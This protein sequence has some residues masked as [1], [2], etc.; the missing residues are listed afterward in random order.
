VHPSPLQQAV[1]QFVSR[2]CQIGSRVVCH[3][4]GLS[5]ALILVASAT[6]CGE[7]HF[8]PSPYTPQE[9]ELIYSS[10]EHITV[11]RWLVSAPLPVA[12]TRFEML[13]PNGY[14]PIDFSQSVFPGGLAACTDGFGTCAQ[15]VVRG[16][17][18]VPTDIKPVQAVHDVYGVLPGGPPTFKTATTTLS[19]QSFFH[20]KNSVVT[21]NITDAVATAG[22]YN[23]PRTYERTMWPTTGLCVSDTAPDGVSF[24][25]LDASSGFPPDQPLT[26]TGTYCVAAR[27]IPADGGD[28]AMVEVRI[29]TLPEIIRSTQ[30]FDPPVERS[31]IVYQIVLDL[32]I[33]VPD[34]CTD[35]ISKIENLTSKYMQGP[36]AEVRMLPTINLAENGSSQCAQTNDRTVDAANM[37]DQVRQTITSLTGKHMQY[38]LMYFNNLDA[39]LPSALTTSLQSLFD[40]LLSWPPNY[41]YRTFSWMFN[42]GAAYASPLSWWAFW[43]WETADKMFDMALADYGRQKLP[44]TSQE[45]DA[46]VPVKLL[47]DDDTTTHAG[48]Q[49]KICASPVTAVTTKP[50]VQ[51]ITTPSWTISTDDPP[52]Y[53]VSIDNQVVVPASEFVEQSVR[54][55]YQI[56]TRFCDHPYVDTA[57]KGEL[58][59][60]DSFSCAGKDD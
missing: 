45:H 13:G 43:V 48:D 59:W 47:S 16:Q 19:L 18:D 58:S 35:V 55:N 4:L 27:P 53:L 6:G 22:P 15:Y 57:G 7:V 44:Y 51:V 10:Q 36:G 1:G 31:P 54:I 46:A 8:V 49:V 2:G 60:T 39:P 11:M 30:V 41:E 24:S 42:P 12:E 3:A 5:T 17:Y 32:E 52:Q 34:R 33:P 23:F 56:C 26:D 9:V 28:A 21:L 40:G 25:P 38:H 20:S 14:E 37:A 50:F 29:A